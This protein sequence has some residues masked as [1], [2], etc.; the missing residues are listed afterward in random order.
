MKTE[1]TSS[2]NIDGFTMRTSR[3][4]IGDKKNSFRVSA[5]LI[6]KH[7]RHRTIKIIPS[8]HEVSSLNRLNEDDDFKEEILTVC[9]SSG[10]IET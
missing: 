1:L 5:Y 9:L 7:K 3:N 10:R 2:C 6:Y 4:N 8:V